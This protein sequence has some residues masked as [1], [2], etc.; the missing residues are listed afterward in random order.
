VPESQIS[1]NGAT[2]RCIASA[3]VSMSVSRVSLLAAVASLLLGDGTTLRARPP[4]AVTGRTPP[5]WRTVAVTSDS[6]ATPVMRVDAEASRPG[7]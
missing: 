6:W 7:A 3:L 2:T 1:R 5:R 4:M